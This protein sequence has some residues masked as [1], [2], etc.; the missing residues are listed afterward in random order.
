M[1]TNDC[2]MRSSVVGGPNSEIIQI[3]TTHSNTIHDHVTHSTNTHIYA[4]SAL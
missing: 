1:M 4:C 2:D 3:S